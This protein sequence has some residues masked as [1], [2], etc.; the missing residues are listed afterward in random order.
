MKREGGGAARGGGEVCE[1]R[2]KGR[3]R[4]QERKVV[5]SVNEIR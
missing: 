2:R 5:F 3:A 1:R 4:I